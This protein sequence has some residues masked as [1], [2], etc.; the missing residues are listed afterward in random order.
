MASEMACRSSICTY[1]DGLN[2]WPDWAADPVRANNLPHFRKTAARLRRRNARYAS[3][4][5]TST[6]I[7]V[8][9]STSVLGSE[10]ATMVSAGR[11]CRGFAHL[12]R[13]S[14]GARSRHLLAVLFF[15][16][17]PRSPKPG[18]SSVRGCTAVDLRCGKTLVAVYSGSGRFGLVSPVL[19]DSP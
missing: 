17:Q 16:A 11:T 8:L 7:P 9:D 5:E 4:C 3:R 1:F 19:A 6:A 15:V 13:C 2:N 18:L 14:C 12:Q 10:A